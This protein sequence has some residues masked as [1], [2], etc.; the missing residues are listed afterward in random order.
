V[1]ETL[2]QTRTYS[3]G[4]GGGDATHPALVVLHSEDEPE[5]VGEVGVVERPTVLGRGPGEDDT[6]R[7]VF[8]RQRP[9]I[10]EPRPPLAERRLSRSQLRIHPRGLELDLRNVGRCPLTVNGNPADRARVKPGDVLRL[11]TLVLGVVLRPR[12][13][14]TL[15]PALSAAMDTDFA[16]GQADDLGWV[17]ESA[18]S[19]RLRESIAFVGGRTG[20]VLVLG[21]SGSGK[22]L[23]ARGLHARSSRSERE[24]VARSAATIPE[25]LAVEELFGNVEDYPTPGSAARDGL[26]GEAHGTSLFLDEIS[27][28]NKTVLAHILRV[29]DADGEFHRLGER[30]ARTSDLRVIATT[31]ARPDA[32]DREVRARFRLVVEVPGLDERMEDVPL[33]L[34]HLLRQGAQDDPLVRQRFLDPD[35]SPR[36]S[37]ELV[38]AA[39]RH[40]ATQH[41]R[42]LDTLLWQ[43]ISTSPGDRVVL[44]EAVAATVDT[45]EPEVDPS[46]LTPEQV[47]RTLDAHDGVLERTWRAL[48]LKNRFQL[49]RLMRKFKLGKYGEE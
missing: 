23:V 1:S 28:A 8:A 15:M 21:P 10:S 47:Q 32:L 48:G 29:L 16:W 2:D 17:G 20:H 22:E 42:E 26:I 43:A 35:G 40:R 9:G 12:V 30:G 38:E 18:A 4:D 13:L 5:R 7:L 19:W 33:L 34:A 3:S 46:S 25:K 24:L 11:R 41:V 6:R 49:I 37:A 44:A 45:P 31:N 39:C 14:P 36:L 27:Q